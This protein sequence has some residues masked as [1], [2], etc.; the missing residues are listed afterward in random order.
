MPITLPPEDVVAFLEFTEG[1]SSDLISHVHS[2]NVR[3]SSGAT[4]IRGLPVTSRTMGLKRQ[5]QKLNSLRLSEI[6][7]GVLSADQRHLLS[8]L[9]SVT[10]L[11]LDRVSFDTAHSMLDFISSFKALHTISFTN[12]YTQKPQI[13][14]ASF[15]MTA[16]RLLQPVHV[17]L[18]ILNLDQPRSI[19]LLIQW[20]MEQDPSPSI[21]IDALRLG[22]LHDHFWLANPCIQRLL[23]SNN[24]VVDCLQIKG[25]R[26]IYGEESKTGMQ[27]Y[28]DLE[29]L[30]AM[31]MWI[32]TEYLRTFIET[33][34]RQAFKSLSFDLILLSM[35]PNNVFDHYTLGIVTGVLRSVTWCSIQY[36][37]ISFVISEW[38]SMI[39]VDWIQ[40]ESILMQPHFDQLRRIRISVYRVDEEDDR[41]LLIKCVS[42]AL[43]SL[44]AR[45]LLIFDFCDEMEGGYY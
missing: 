2:L 44:F 25:S 45:G 23:A 36:L 32:S 19:T 40:I 12:W 43:P 21:R 15:L 8:R 20:L 9:P 3:R 27:Y 10:R 31:L 5:L 18:D 39:H 11:E 1:S 14:L 16:P 7:W 6:F 22:P 42:D 17:H 41:I 38:E 34:R 33:L 35:P 24:T 37:S 13:E 29:R 28:R 4:F 26:I 30:L